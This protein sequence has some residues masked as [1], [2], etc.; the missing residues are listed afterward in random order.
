MNKRYI[1]QSILIGGML[2]MIT[3]SMLAQKTPS[4]ADTTASTTSSIM[5]PGRLFSTSKNNNTAAI[6]TVSGETLYKTPAQNI[7]NTLYGLLPGL[8]V[9]QGSGEPG[10]DN[11]KLLIRGV[12]SYGY[13]GY[14][15]CKIF[16]DGFEVNS[17]YFS[18]LS[19]AEIES[20]SV[21]K[22]A[23]ALATL[24]MRGSNGVIWVETKRGKIGKPLF[25]IQ[26]RTGMQT[27]EI[28]NKPLNSY[29]FANL[30]N[31]AISNDNG[32][33]WTPKYSTQN[34]QGYQNGTG[35]NVDW[36]KQVLKN[37]GSYT[38]ADF[39]FKG[40]NV[41]TKY[42]V[43]L[44]YA[45]QGGLYN[46]SNTDQT[47]NEVM[48]RYNLRANLDF[49]M[50]NIFEA[51]IDLGGRIEERKSPNYST[52]NLMND[53]ARYPSNIYPVHDGDTTLY[54]GTTLYPNNPVGSIMGLGWASTHTRTLQSNF[55]LK[56]KLDFI[57]RGLYLNEAYSFNAYSLSTYNKTKNYARYINGATTTTDLTTSIVASGYGS[58]GQED[59][60]Q[61]IVTLGYAR[62][63]GEHAITSALNFHQ[64]DYKGDGF[65]GYQNH[66]Q[67]YSGRFNYSYNNRLVAEFGFS[68]FGDDAYAP[69][70]Q[71]G[72]YPTISGAWIVSNESFL[73]T[74]KVINSLKIRGSVGKSGGSDSGAN[75]F[76][77]SFSSNGRFLYQQYYGASIGQFYTGNSTPTWANTL[78]P[79]FIPNNNVFAEQSLKYNAGADIILF[80]KL[81][82]SLDL[83]MDKRSGILTLDNSIMGYYGSNYYFSNVGKMTNKGFEVSAS[84]S[85]KVG[86]VGYSIN[87]MA[88]YSKNKIDYM[89]E[90]TPAFPYNAQTGRSF[91]TPVG[92]QAIGYYQLSD[93]NADGSLK[94]GIPVPAFGAIQPGDIRY[95]DLNNDGHVDQTD[96]TSIGKSPYP[97]LT[98]AFGGSIN[99]K[100]FDLSILFQGT[101]G[102][103]VNLLGSS[104]NQVVAFVNNG[105]AYDIAKGAWA[106]YPEQGIDTRATATYPR[107]TTKGN[108]N[109]YQNSSFWMKS[110]DFLR[111]RNIELS[112]NFSNQILS[113]CGL[114]KLSLFVNATNP[115]TWSSLLKDYHIDPE[116]MSG[117]PVLK[118]VNVGITAS[119]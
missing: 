101:Y 12:G 61:G 53:L 18:Y 34:L 11:A 90:V 33:F 75:G 23:A 63:F 95:K 44:N 105:N 40:G 92:L 7:T 27:P 39:T 72:F 80:K 70:N 67:N 99:Y 5:I 19:P 9:T 68:Y 4:K 86:E 24:G 71:W 76:L 85:E 32:M 84:Y 45:N 52:S 108:T 54:S 112:Y 36:Y 93:F 103:S 113:K 83:F 114:S 41:D 88:S 82:A 119:F 49:N 42:N 47:S 111:I 3:G 8:T 91:G 104:Y 118:S 55:G 73:K 30:Y 69:G 15:V 117:Y 6:S 21:L 1:I 107:L 58:A 50:F 77:S 109:N 62:Q 60:R 64:S 81:K 65:F 29:D 87:G 116:S 102:S 31:Q 26:F 96:V 115:V 48:N 51:R 14:N 28:I 22:D 110:G 16:V 35:T 43:V 74:N 94:N 57:T 20:V 98:Y 2:S 89:A 25:Q 97:E 10:Y 79:V 56:E 100:G 38:D 106:Y 66:Y 78:A 46:V 17:N 13:G 59:W 37:N